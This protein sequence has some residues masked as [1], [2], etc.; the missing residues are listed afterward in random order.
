M[1]IKYHQ[2]HMKEWPD[3]AELDI[4]THPLKRKTIR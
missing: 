2:G 4:S 1:I 3:M